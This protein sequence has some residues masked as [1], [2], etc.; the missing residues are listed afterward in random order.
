MPPPP[1]LLL[2]VSTGEHPI[3][4]CAG[5]VPPMNDN[6]ARSQSADAHRA[7]LVYAERANHEEK[8]QFGDLQTQ[9]SKGLPAQGMASQGPWSALG[10]KRIHAHPP[11]V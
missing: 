1:P 7:L 10:L 3:P 9:A 4:R 8:G 6:A 2:Q 11:L 5:L